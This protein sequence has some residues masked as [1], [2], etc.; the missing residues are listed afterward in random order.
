M[1][2]LHRQVDLDGHIGSRINQSIATDCRTFWP[3][4]PSLTT[5]KTCVLSCC[6]MYHVLYT[7]HNSTQH[8]FCVCVWWCHEPQQY[9]GFLTFLDISRLSIYVAMCGFRGTLH[10][11]SL[12]TYI[13]LYLFFCKQ[14]GSTF[15][16]NRTTQHCFPSAVPSQECWESWLS[17]VT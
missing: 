15:P 7:W 6:G 13:H 11:S 12:H 14:L 17:A 8:M 10:P 16:Q 3:R 2:F 9:H 1:W 5:C 4:R